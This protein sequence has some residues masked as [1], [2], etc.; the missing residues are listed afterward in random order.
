MTKETVKK[1]LVGAASFIIAAVF[2]LVG[3]VNPL[4]EIGAIIA[5]AGTFFVLSVFYDDFIEDH[6]CSKM[7]WVVYGCMLAT[8]GFLAIGIMKSIT[9]LFIFAGAFAVAAVVCYAIE[10][11]LAKAALEANTE[12]N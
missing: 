2:L 1:I 11:K 4:Q 6:K 12:K 3:G 5:V 7:M 8:V 9:T 10:K